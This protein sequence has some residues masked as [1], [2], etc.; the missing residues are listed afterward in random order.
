MKRV[1]TSF[2][3]ISQQILWWRCLRTLLDRAFLA[4]SHVLARDYNAENS[5]KAQQEANS[6]ILGASRL[7]EMAD[8]L[9]A[10]LDKIN[11]QIS[12]IQA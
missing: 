3:I 2:G 12:A 6:I 11:G 8:S 1:Y 9:Q 5:G 4:A 7:G 10:E